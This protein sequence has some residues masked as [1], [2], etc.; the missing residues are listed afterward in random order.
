MIIVS[1]IYLHLFL[2]HSSIC[3]P[4]LYSSFSFSWKRD[5]KATQTSTKTFQTLLT[6]MKKEGRQGWKNN[7][8]RPLM[9]IDEFWDKL[10]VSIDEFGSFWTLK[11]LNPSLKPSK[12]IEIHQHSFLDF[13]RLFL[14]VRD[15]FLNVNWLIVSWETYWINQ[16]KILRK[17]RVAVVQGRKSYVKC[18]RG[19]R[20]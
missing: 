12:L 16:S 11:F 14:V 7:T 18:D 20:K 13:H 6:L 1:V 17:E 19:I 3:F 8:E 9:V 5:E 15:V 4:P 2:F 10:S